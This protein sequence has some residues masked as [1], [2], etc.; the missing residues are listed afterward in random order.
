ME[1]NQIMDPDME[2]IGVANASGAR[3]RQAEENRKLVNH[4]SSE[5][6]KNRK[7]AWW[8]AF[9]SMAIEAGAFAVGATAAMIAVHH[10]MMAHCI[11]APIFVACVVRAAICVDRF[12]RGRYA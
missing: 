11:G 8:R 12:K 10:G 7:D 4:M 3:R 2:A 6:R 5:Q 9:W 1:I